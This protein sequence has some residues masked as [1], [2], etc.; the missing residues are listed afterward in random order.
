MGQVYKHLWRIYREIKFFLQVQISPVLCFISIYNLFSDSPLYNEHA[1]H[2][3]VQNTT[4]TGG[5]IDSSVHIEVGWAARVR[6][7]AG[8]R[9]FFLLHTVQTSS[10]VQTTSNRYHGLSLWVVKQPEREANYS[11]PSSPE[12]MN[13]GDVPPYP[14]IFHSMVHNYIIPTSPFYLI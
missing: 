1:V 14:H 11:P 10:G 8:A 13:G 4:W 6:F 12:V 2:K 5:V 7:L 3:L 9:D